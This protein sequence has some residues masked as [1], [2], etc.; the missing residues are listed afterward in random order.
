M[1]VEGLSLDIGERPQVPANAARPCA[2]VVVRECH[3]RCED[4]PLLGTP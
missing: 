1:L 3:G 4:K 2:T